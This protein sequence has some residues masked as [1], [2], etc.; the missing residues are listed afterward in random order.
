MQGLPFTIKELNDKVPVAVIDLDDWMC[1]SEA[2]QVSFKYCSF[3]FKRELPYN[4]FFLYYQNRPTPWKYWRDRLA[5]QFYKVSN[6]SLGIE[7]RRYDDLKSKRVQS[8]DIDVFFCG[9]TTS[10]PRGDALKKL[11]KMSEEGQWKIVIDRGLSF[12]EYCHKMARS[13]ITISI[14]GGGWDCFRHYEAVAL[15]S[16]PVMDTPLV[17][18]I[19]WRKQP[20]EL[21]FSNDFSDFEE[22]IIH[23]L[24]N[25]KLR[26]NCFNVLERDVE[27]HMLH[28][29]MVNHVVSTV[30][31][32]NSSFKQKS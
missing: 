23:L 7:D 10:S 11:L 20:A 17:D 2:N 18:V 27:N 21:F 3:Y 19:W 9:E 14:S 32:N 16:L 5:S 31:A 25:V 15:G 24:E 4:R 26:K 8:Q 12:E 13:K 22:K 6:V 1:L 28:S 29:K 30:L